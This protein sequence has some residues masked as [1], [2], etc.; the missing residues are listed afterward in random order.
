MEEAQCAQC[1]RKIDPIGF[2]LENFNAAGLW[3]TEELLAT[4][5]GKN[6]KTKGEPK[7]F[8]IDP[9]GQLP[10]GTAFQDF[11]GL[12]DA[13]ATRTDVFTRGLTEALIEYALGRPFGFA[14]EDLADELATASKNNGYQFRQI[15]QSLVASEAFHKK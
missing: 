15:I 1:H 10:D 4:T 7:G 6:P 5:K 3:R 11:F 8:P 13:I 12:R 14:D 9:K 2:G